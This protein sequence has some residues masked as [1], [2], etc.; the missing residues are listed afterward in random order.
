MTTIL[1]QAAAKNTTH[2]LTLNTCQE[3]RRQRR[4][5]AEDKQLR[6]MANRPLDSDARTRTV[7]R[8]LQY[9]P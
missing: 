1:S 4:T 8:V 3:D 2:F 7:N 9:Q 5:Q 6:T